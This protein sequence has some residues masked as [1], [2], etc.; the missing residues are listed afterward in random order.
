MI[1]NETKKQYQ[2]EIDTRSE[3]QEYWASIISI[4]AAEVEWRETKEKDV[5]ILYLSY[6]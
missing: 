1:L 5:K 6:A 4:V 3:F 2:I